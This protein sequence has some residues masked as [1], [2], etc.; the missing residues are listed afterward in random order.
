M[1]DDVISDVIALEVR[2]HVAARKPEAM[3]ADVAGG[4]WG[5]VEASF[6]KFLGFV[7]LRP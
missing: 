5:R 1:E 7:D 3:N 4:A 6:L 2:R